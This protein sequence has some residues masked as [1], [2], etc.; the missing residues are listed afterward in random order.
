MAC[1]SALPLASFKHLQGHACARSGSWPSSVR[2]SVH[3]DTVTMS[4]LCG[5]SQLWHRYGTGRLCLCGLKCL[6]GICTAL[7][8]IIDSCCDSP[9]HSKGQVIGLFNP[10]VLVLGPGLSVLGGQCGTGSCPRH[11]HIGWV[12][13]FGLLVVIALRPRLPVRLSDGCEHARKDVGFM[14]G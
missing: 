1:G 3:G 7:C 14:V 4:K 11:L 5:S 10:R 6:I 8:F 13:R 12:C 9:R 2:G